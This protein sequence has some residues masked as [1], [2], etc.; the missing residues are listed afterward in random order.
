MVVLPQLLGTGRFLLLLAVRV[1]AVLSELAVPVN[2]DVIAHLRLVLLARR[3]Q[4]PVDEVGTAAKVRMAAAV[5]AAATGRRRRRQR[6]IV[7]IVAR[8]AKETAA[9]VVWHGV[10]LVEGRG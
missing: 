1:V 3:R 10:V 9:V 5:A 2:E 7:A 4:R 6:A 8:G